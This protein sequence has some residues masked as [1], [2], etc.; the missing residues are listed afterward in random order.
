MSFNVV[1]VPLKK[2]GDFGPTNIR[3]KT[4]N[5]TRRWI[6]TYSGRQF[7]PLTP[8]S[9]DV[10]IE[11]IA[12]ALSLTCRYS[13]HCREFY[14]VAQHSCLMLDIY[15]R[16][17]ND[18]YIESPHDKDRAMLLL[19]DA[20]EAY[21]PDIATPIKDKINGFMQIEHDVLCAVYAKYDIPIHLIESPL[22]KTIDT[23]MLHWEK[24]DVMAREPA[25]WGLLDIPI[26]LQKLE[27]VQP[28]C[29]TEAKLRFLELGKM[30]L[31]PGEIEL[32]I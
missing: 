23:I 21:L 9:D 28:W 11:D 15:Q 17:S 16:L 1:N 24:R 14:S 25:D 32:L 2:V 12:H 4:M 6:Q 10:C 27:P 29:C 7:W 22:R 31:V 13:G 19:H 3:L 20:G 26:D 30:L 5:D 18:G 8:N